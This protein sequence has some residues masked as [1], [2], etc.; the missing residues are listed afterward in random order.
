M[1]QRTISNSIINDFNLIEEENGLL[2]A[3]EF[4][5]KPK[6]NVKLPQKFTDTYSVSSFEVITPGNDMDFVK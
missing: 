5:W 4:K 3:Y 6:K 1:I 2:K